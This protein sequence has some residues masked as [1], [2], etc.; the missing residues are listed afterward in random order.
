MRKKVVKLAK[1][2]DEEK[3]G[4]SLKV[5]KN[6]KDRLYVFSE[7]EDVSMNALI[8]S[9]IE[10]M[11]DDTCGNL[12]T[13]IDIF[14]VEE[15]GKLSHKMEDFE[16]IDEDDEKRYEQMKIQNDRYMKL[17]HQVRDLI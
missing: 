8:T 12:L 4:I 15:I 7:Q 16:L 3:V 9:C 5:P 11:L 17:F 14:L 6:L 10:L 1:G 13:Q 2:Q